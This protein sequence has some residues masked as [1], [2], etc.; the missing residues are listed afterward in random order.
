MRY[1][2]GVYHIN[3][4][5]FHIILLVASE[6]RDKRSRLDPIPQCLGR[7]F[8]NGKFEWRFLFSAWF[9]DLEALESRVQLPVGIVGGSRSRFASAQGVI[10]HHFTLPAPAN[11]H[12]LG[13]SKMQPLC[14]KIKHHFWSLESDTFNVRRFFECHLT[15]V[16][17]WIRVVR[18]QLVM[19]KD[20]IETLRFF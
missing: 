2:F 5:C 20:C 10:D 18:F 1:Q 8:G 9:G 16:K 3:I 19:G 4:V 17:I 12:Y 6:F 14:Q 11:V 7:S 15:Y 13:A